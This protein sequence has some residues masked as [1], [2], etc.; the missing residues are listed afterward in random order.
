MKSAFD[1]LYEEVMNKRDSNKLSLETIS[2]IV[3]KIPDGKKTHIE[4]VIAESIL[5]F[6]GT[7]KKNYIGDKLDSLEISDD[8][9]SLGFVYLR[10]MVSAY[11]D[12]SD[13]IIIK[14]DSN[15]IIRIG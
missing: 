7:V 6:E 4:V 10:T 8:S 15:T 11:A 13:K 5:Q 1:K 12:D 9:K 14:L 2:S 3:E